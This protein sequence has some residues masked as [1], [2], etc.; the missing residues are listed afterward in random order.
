MPPPVKYFAAV[1]A[2]CRLILKSLGIRNR[3]EQQPIRL[4]HPMELSYRPRSIG[5]THVL[6]H[7]RNHHGV[8]TTRL[9]GHF[10]N[11]TDLGVD[12]NFKHVRNCRRIWIKRRNAPS[13]SEQ[14]ALHP[15][16][17]NSNIQYS[18]TAGS[19][20]NI[21]R[22]CH[23]SRNCISKPV[24]CRVL[25][26]RPDLFLFHTFLYQHAPPAPPPKGLRSGIKLSQL[27][28]TRGAEYPA[29]AF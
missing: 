11:V 8:K 6:K 12:P 24:V 16:S 9:K 18:L 13:L 15:P 19:S 5:I 14:C 1:R 22:K 4:Q 26:M 17:S 2:N 23:I 7:L 3:S 29:T 27:S 21:G 20:P 28:A 25:K 10:L